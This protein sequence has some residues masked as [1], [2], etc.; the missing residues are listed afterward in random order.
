ML[1]YSLHNKVRGQEDFLMLYLYIFNDI[2][3]PNN[4]SE[5]TNSKLLIFMYTFYKYTVCFSGNQTHKNDVASD[6]FLL[7]L[8]MYT[9]AWP[10]K[11]YVLN[12]RD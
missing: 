7:C 9:V 3:L 5:V 11:M 8:S 1:L 4:D 2:Y 10:I 12:L 6:P